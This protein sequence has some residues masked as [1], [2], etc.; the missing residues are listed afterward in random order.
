MANVNAQA[1][2]VSSIGETDRRLTKVERQLAVPRTAKSS[3]AGSGTRTSSTAGV[4]TGGT[5]TRDQVTVVTTA[6]CLI[7]VVAEVTLNTSSG[8]SDATVHLVDDTTGTL[9]QLLST[10]STTPELRR[11]AQGLSRGALDPILG[12]A[13]SF[14]PPAAWSPATG[15]HS[16]SLYYAAAGSA[17]VTASSRKLFAWVTPF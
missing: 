8:V 7:S 11:S 16:F 17:T 5:T 3:I 2:L 6:S 9:Y 10:T 13:V 15:P 12:G 1:D 4:L 14:A